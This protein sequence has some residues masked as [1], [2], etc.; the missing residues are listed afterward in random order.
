VIVFS[1][2]YVYTCLPVYVY[3]CLPVVRPVKL[4]PVRKSGKVVTG[5]HI[6]NFIP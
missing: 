2:V 3:T 5:L 1:L 6:N 4:V